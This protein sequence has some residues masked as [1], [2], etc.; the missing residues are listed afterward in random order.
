MALSLAL[1]DQ[2]LDH[3]PDFQSSLGALT[4]VPAK[5]FSSPHSFKLF[6]ER[7]KIL[8]ITEHRILFWYLYLGVNSSLKF[9]FLSEHWRTLSYTTTLWSCEHE[10]SDHVSISHQ[11]L[12][13]LWLF[14]S[15]QS[16]NSSANLCCTCCRVC[17]IGL[18]TTPFI[19]HAEQS[20]SLDAVQVRRR[21]LRHKIVF[22]TDS[23]LCDE[24]T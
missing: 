16:W 21:I 10:R 20:R 23:T 13:E 2:L 22:T 6:V 1:M 24:H 14:A 7:K 15:L 11:P 4:K 3:V 17:F 9:P 18:C 12:S 19:S 5:N 8:E